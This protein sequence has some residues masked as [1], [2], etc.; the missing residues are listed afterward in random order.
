MTDTLVAR[1]WGP[2]VS[3]DQPALGELVLSSGWSSGPCLGSAVREW[4][5]PRLSAAHIAELAL[6]TVAL[7]ASL[8]S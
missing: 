4:A 7:P 5:L 3:G 1:L 2:G 6:S 8:R